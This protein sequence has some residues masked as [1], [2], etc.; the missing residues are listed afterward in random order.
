MGLPVG[1]FVRSGDYPSIKPHPCITHD[2]PWSVAQIFFPIQATKIYDNR[3]IVMTLVHDVRNKC[4]TIFRRYPNIEELVKRMGWSFRVQPEELV[5]KFSSR[6][7]TPGREFL[8]LLAI[9]IAIY[10]AVSP[11]LVPHC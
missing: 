6:R 1:K 7:D 11:A 8:R 10:I 2:N 3:Q 4:E 5:I 9:R